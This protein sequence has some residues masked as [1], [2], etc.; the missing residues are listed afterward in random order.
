VPHLALLVCYGVNIFT[1]V[2]RV[3]N[4]VCGCVTCAEFSIVHQSCTS[5][6]TSVHTSITRRWKKKK[7]E[8]TLVGPLH[9]LYYW[10]PGFWT[11]VT[12]LLKCKRQPVR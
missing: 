5:V 6:L 7:T 4:V 1:A 11:S 10:T 9:Y 8:A 12:Y 2:D 3:D